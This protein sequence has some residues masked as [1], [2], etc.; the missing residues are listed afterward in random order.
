MSFK[1]NWD[2]FIVVPT[3]TDRP[4]YSARNTVDVR[5][6]R[7]S[8]DGLVIGLVIICMCIAPSECS[9]FTNTKFTRPSSQISKSSHARSWGKFA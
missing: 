7:L 9:H 4:F 5:L 8:S 1:N 6:P 3:A 2:G